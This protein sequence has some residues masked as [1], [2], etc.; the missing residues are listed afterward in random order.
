M[1]QEMVS[2][3]IYQESLYSKLKQHQEIQCNRH[4][5]EGRNNPKDIS[6]QISKPVYKKCTPAAAA[7]LIAAKV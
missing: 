5:N 3:P 6:N 4:A 1:G 7:V 2:R